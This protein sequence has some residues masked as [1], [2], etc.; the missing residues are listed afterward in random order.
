MKLNGS[1]ILLECL[2][3][4]KV[5][6]VFGYPG[7]AVLNIY[8]ALYKYGGK[9]RHIRTS[10]EQGA[11]HA[12]DG[13]ARSTG[14][15]G[16]V[17]A[18]SGPG[19]T[20]LVTGIATAY[21]D[22]VPLVAITGQVPTT[23]LGKDSFQEIDITGITIPITKHNYIV[24]DVDKLADIVREAFLIAKTGRPGP[25][26]IDICKNVTSAYAEYEKKDDYYSHRLDKLKQNCECETGDLEKAAEI[27]N[28]AK[29][30]FVLS[31][32]GVTISDSNE[33]LYEMVMKIKSPV[34]TTLMG[35]SS[36]PVKNSLFT[37]LVGMHGSVTSNR[38]ANSCDLLIAVGARFSDRVVGDIEKFASS[39]KVIHIDVDPA[40]IGRAHV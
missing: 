5:D 13:Y 30:P 40:E 35:V 26:L 24:K 29:R 16:V 4:Q 20:N 18:T 10:H 12:A 33:L 15:T 36:F 37:G 34:A 31:G 39:A 32:G 6:T 11:C 7:G 27:I 19:A 28:E 14:K 25:V 9:I 38:A 3:E 8:D 23:L 22:S 21:M 1:E 2:L 17:I